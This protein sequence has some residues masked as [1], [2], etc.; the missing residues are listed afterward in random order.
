MIG[1]LVPINIIVEIVVSRPNA[2]H[3][4]MLGL[5]L[6]LIVRVDHYELVI[7]L[8]RIRESRYIML[9]MLMVIRLN[10]LLEGPVHLH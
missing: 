10:K 5:L 1:G 7:I 8:R 9:L 4:F 6:L 3:A 2:V